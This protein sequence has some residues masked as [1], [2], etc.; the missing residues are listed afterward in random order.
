MSL[1]LVKIL[2]VKLTLKII[3]PKINMNKYIISLK[4]YLYIKEN[5]RIYYFIW[6]MNNIYKII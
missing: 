6:G 1:T 2:I 4:N 3:L 5:K